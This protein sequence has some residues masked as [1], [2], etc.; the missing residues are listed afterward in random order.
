MN[1][2]TFFCFTFGISNRVDFW[3]NVADERQRM[4]DE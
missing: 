3:E 4:D 2:V 1:L